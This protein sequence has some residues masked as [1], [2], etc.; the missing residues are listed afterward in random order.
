[1]QCAGHVQGHAGPWAWFFAV[2]PRQFFNNDIHGSGIY[3]WGDGRKYE[4][5]WEGPDPASFGD[6][7]T[8]CSPG[9][10]MHGNGKF[11]W[12]WADSVARL[13]FGLFV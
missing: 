13:R 2:G 12:S 9:N 10:R 6:L 11:S 7:I 8:M 5:Q 1:M 4:G 3:S